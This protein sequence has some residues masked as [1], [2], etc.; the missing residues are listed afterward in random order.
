MHI[1][2]YI[3]ICA[4]IYVHV[5]IYN[6]Y[7]IYIYIYVPCWLLRIVHCVALLLCLEDA[8]SD[9]WNVQVPEQISKIL[10]VSMAVC[11]HGIAISNL[12]N[13]YIC[14]HT[15]NICIHIYIYT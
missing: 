8:A 9:G 14:M 6:K 12:G 15:N 7:N 3:H 5:Y 13:I 1:S 2:I 4:Y 11:M 10:Y